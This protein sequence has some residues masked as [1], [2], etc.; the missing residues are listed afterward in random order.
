MQQNDGPILLVED[1]EVDIMII[2]RALRELEIDHEVAYCGDGEEAL[3]YLLCC[4]KELPCL[5]L[6][7]LNMPKMNG[8]EFLRV[9]KRD[10]R[11]KKIPIVV[12]TTSKAQENIAECFALGA[13]G[14]VV[15]PVNYEKFV[16]ALRTLDSYWTLSRIPANEE[17]DNKCLQEQDK[18]AVNT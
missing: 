3:K 16:E 5:I 4:I 10:G 6:L 15:K 7:D 9:A 8:F 2:R 18:N 17:K 13:A 11:L 14:Y 1:D 12:L